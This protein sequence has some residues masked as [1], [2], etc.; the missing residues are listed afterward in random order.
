M[1]DLGPRA[2]V[3]KAW[4]AN[5][6]LTGAGIVLGLITLAA[7][8]GLAVDPREIT[9][10]PA[11]AK[12]ARFAFSF[13]L[14][15]VT[16]LWLL[17]F[18]RSHQRLVRVISWVTAVAVVLEVLWVVRAAAAGTTSHFNFSTRLVS[19]VAVTMLVIISVTAL[20][21]LLTIVLLLFQRVQPP[22]LAWALSLGL[23]IAIAGMA[24]AVPMVIAPTAVQEAAADRGLG[25]PI[26]GGHS[27]GQVD[28]GP[29]MP[30]TNFN[31]TAGDLR[32]PHFVGVHAVQALSLI[33]LLLTLGPRSLGPRHRV[34]L[35]WIAATALLG[36][37]GVLTWQASRGQALTAP[38]TGTVAALIGWLG[39]VAA[40][41]TAVFVHARSAPPPPVQENVG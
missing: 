8:V 2:V 36:L 19:I 40:A 18:V 30:I 35:V 37:M 26:I 12:P 21:G 3:Q 24:V 33:G 16:L 29:G 9:G 27:V 13:A 17:T 39:A 20:M 34:V 11:W 6:P 28:G 41:T 7:L 1:K 14:Y 5:P 22:A 31:T 10:Q 32:V 25:M 38:D 23:A 15:A 4:A